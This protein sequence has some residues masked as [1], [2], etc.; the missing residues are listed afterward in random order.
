MN[1]LIGITCGH[2]WSDPERFYV[3]GP[4]IHGITAA[5]GIPILVPY[6]DR[7]KLEQILD[8]I[9]ALLV[10]GGIDVD[11]KH[12]NQDLHPKSGIINPW[13]DELDITMIRGALA[14]NLPILA[15]CRGCQVLNVACGGSLIQ[16]IESFVS[17]PIKH[18]QQ[19]PKWYPTHAVSIEQG[20]LLAQIFGTEV[21]RV[22]SFHHQAVE[23]AAPG[24]RVTAR[25]SDGVIEAI[26]STK[27]SFVIGVQW[28]PELMTSHDAKMQSLFDHF[29]AAA[30]GRPK[31]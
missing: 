10:P 31:T 9:D 7:A 11:A 17:Q 5:G 8:R 19:A 30:M 1:P 22:N 23:Q 12:Y 26:E 14:R 4:Y 29:T 24:L 18:Q 6:L 27:H 13:W 2:Q 20:S 3:N 21:V 25:A 28:H 16:D 15:I